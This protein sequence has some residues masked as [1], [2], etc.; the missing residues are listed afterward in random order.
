MMTLDQIWRT[1]NTMEKIAATIL[2]LGLIIRPCSAADGFLDKLGLQKPFSNA[3]ASTLGVGLSQ[4]EISG[5]LKEALSKG[6]ERAV[7]SLGREDGFLK[8][9]A[10]KIPMPET[11]RK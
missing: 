9:S 3:S 11:L 2:A 6:V 4:D 8:N 5:G 10:V 1:I 7:S